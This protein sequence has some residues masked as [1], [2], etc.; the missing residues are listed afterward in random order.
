MASGEEYAVDLGCGD[1]RPT[2]LASALH[3]ADHPGRKPGLLEE[4]EHP[5]AD[6]RRE[7]AR[8]EYD[9]VAGEQGRDDM[10]VGQMT[11]QVEGTEYR[12][13]PDRP[14]MCPGHRP[15]ELELGLGASLGE[16][17]DRDRELRDHG[18]DFG[19]CLPA[20]LARLARERFAEFGAGRPEPGFIGAQVIDSSCDRGRS[21]FGERLRSRRHGGAHLFVACLVQSIQQL[22]RAG[23][24]RDQGWAF[25]IEPNAPDVKACS[26]RTL[27]P[28]GL[29]AVEAE[30]GGR[31]GSRSARN[32]A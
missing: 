17:L 5:R 8:L 11:R 23:I 22:S 25:S 2:D 31:A 4:L 14:V 30:L 6:T 3:E 20:R 18:V 12:H 1:Q 10:P 19:D 13:Y 7:L 21:P 29:A 28:R 27:P 32:G 24:D 15:P 9:R 26:H 16:H